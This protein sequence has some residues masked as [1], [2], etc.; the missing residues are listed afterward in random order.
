[1]RLAPISGRY[2]QRSDAAATVTAAASASGYADSLFVQKRQVR[3]VA[4]VFHLLDGNKMKG[5]GVNYIALSRR[6]FRIGKDMTEP[7]VASLGAYLRALHV[8][9]VVRDLDEEVLRDWFGECG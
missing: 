8:V 1:T 7:S 2:D 4:S 5:G 6:R 3:L 9:G